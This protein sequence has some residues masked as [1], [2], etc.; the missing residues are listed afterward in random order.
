[1][2]EFPSVPALSSLNSTT[3]FPLD[4]VTVGESSGWSVN[5]AGNV[6]ARLAGTSRIFNFQQL[7]IANSI[8]YA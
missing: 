7:R 8:E 6:S 1:M 2:P 4:G 3:G 5:S